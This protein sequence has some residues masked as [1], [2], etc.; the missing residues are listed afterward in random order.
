VAASLTETWFCDLDQAERMAR[1]VARH[2]RFGKSRDAA[3]AWAGGTDQRNAELIEKTR[4]RADLVVPADLL[5]TLGRA[6]P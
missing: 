2:E 1:L 6:L 3:V 4:P 5:R